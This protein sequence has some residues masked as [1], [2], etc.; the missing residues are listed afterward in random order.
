MKAI[1]LAGGKGVRLQP[2][3]DIFPKPLLPIGK[4]PILEIIIRQLKSYGFNEIIIA[5]GHF[6]ELIITYFGDGTKYGIEIT[7]SREKDPLGTIGPLASIKNQIDD[8]FLVMNGDILSAINYLDLFTYHIK[9]NYIAT[10]ALTK[11][12][13]DI[14]FGV[15]EIDNNKCINNYTEKPTIEYL[16]NAGIYIFDPRI[17][18]YIK[19][20]EKL[21]FPDLLKKL[22][23]NRESIKGYIFKDYWLDIGEPN[24]YIKANKDIDKILKK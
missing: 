1:L 7:Y 4:K 22:I 5:V 10:I 2:Y 11:K 6:A 17:L 15:V 16:I 14:N 23:S 3:T 20:N 8:H 24:N 13:I 18:E 9:N 19:Q 12:E 21:D